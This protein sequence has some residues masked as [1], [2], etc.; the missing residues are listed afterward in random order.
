MRRLLALALL[1]P[2]PALA[3]PD[4]L[5]PLNRAI[6]ALNG[7]VRA[8]ALDPLVAAWRRHV[9]APLREGGAGVVRNLAEPMTAASA[10]AAGDAALAWHAARRFALN[11]ALGWG[12]WRDAAAE[13]G[14]APR[15]MTPGE[16][17]CAWGVPSGPYL[18]L[19]LLGPTTLRDAGAAAGLGAVL[20]AGLGT[21]PVLAQ[22]G[23]EAFLDYE[24]AREG[25]LSL[26]AGALDPYAALRAALAQRRAARCPADRPEAAE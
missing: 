13:R 22:R 2:G 1:L 15:A 3:A 18:V 23:A 19:P 21:A 20:A 6:H 4:P 16:A 9:P 26:E 7:E 11:T 5:E 25:L 14:L 12:G 24:A 17:L 10:L 8:R